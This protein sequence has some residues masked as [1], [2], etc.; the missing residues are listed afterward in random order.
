MRFFVALSITFVAAFIIFAST[1]AAAKDMSAA[2]INRDSESLLDF[3]LKS[4]AFN[5]GQALFV[6]AAYVT[7]SVSIDGSF[8]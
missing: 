1:R 7:I 3:Y 8:E 6:A 4:V 5:I 2:Y